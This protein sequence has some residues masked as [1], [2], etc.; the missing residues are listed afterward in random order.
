MILNKRHNF[1]AKTTIRCFQGIT[2]RFNFFSSL[3]GAFLLSSAF[4]FSAWIFKEN[5][6]KLSKQIS[7][8]QK[9]ISYASF[10]KF[11][12]LKF[13]FESFPIFMQKSIKSLLCHLKNELVHKFF[14]IFS[15]INAKLSAHLHKMM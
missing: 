4:N 8:N 12:I 5:K 1:P 15:D 2:V 13:D 14:F 10:E 7:T 6:A 3:K 11:T 9:I